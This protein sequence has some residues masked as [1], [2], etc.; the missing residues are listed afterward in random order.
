MAIVTLL[1]SILFIA[2]IIHYPTLTLS[3]Q[4][5]T[6]DGQIKTCFN[7]YSYPCCKPL[8]NGTIIDKDCIDK[9]SPGQQNQTSRSSN[10]P[11]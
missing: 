8:A 4:Q 7:P 6:S 3:Y 11:Y 10:F 5:P 9:T 1:I 2:T